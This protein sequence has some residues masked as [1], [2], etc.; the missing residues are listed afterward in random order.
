MDTKRA[1]MAL[2]QLWK[3]NTKK[4]YKYIWGLS[5]LDR[6]TSYTHTYIFCPKNGGVVGGGLV[7]H[8][9]IFLFVLVFKLYI[10]IYMYMYHIKAMILYI[11]FQ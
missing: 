4:I 9:S 11:N 2:L 3:T 6:A 7:W 10:C 5:T 8:R 1:E